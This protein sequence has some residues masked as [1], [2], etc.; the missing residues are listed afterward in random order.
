M[1][2]RVIQ[3]LTNTITALMKITISQKIQKLNDYEINILIY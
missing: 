2:V 3:R 1:C